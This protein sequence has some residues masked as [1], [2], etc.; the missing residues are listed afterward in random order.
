MQMR[1]GGPAGLADESDQIALCHADAVDDAAREALQMRVQRRVLLVMADLD[2]IAVAA[3]PAGE[4]NECR[5]PLLRTLVPGGA[6]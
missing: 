1:P 6:E 4:I 3:L 2:D 5:R